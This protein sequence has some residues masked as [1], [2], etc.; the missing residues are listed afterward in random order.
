MKTW[1]GIGGLFGATERMK[2]TRLL[3]LALQEMWPVPKEIRPEVIERLRSIALDTSLT[4]RE[5][6]SASKALLAAS[7]LNV[8]IVATAV[9]VREAEELVERLIELETIVK[10]DT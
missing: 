6:T 10:G 1:G 3:A 8:D 4:P 9:R 2:E 7:R 5:N